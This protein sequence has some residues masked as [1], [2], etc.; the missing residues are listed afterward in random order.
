MK[1]KPEAADRFCGPD[2]ED[3][4]DR[5]M[6]SADRYVKLLRLNAPY[7]ILETERRLLQVHALA[8]QTKQDLFLAEQKQ[9]IDA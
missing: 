4:L 2:A 3:E 7:S 1:K 9:E 6:W 8:A 5:L